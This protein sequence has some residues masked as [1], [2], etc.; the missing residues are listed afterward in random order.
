MGAG[1]ATDGFGPAL[2]PCLKQDAVLVAGAIEAAVFAEMHPHIALRQGQQP[3]DGFDGDVT[4]GGS[5][6][7]Q[8]EFAVAP[9]D[10]G[11]PVPQGGVERSEGGAGGVLRGLIRPDSTE[12]AGV[13]LDAQPQ[14][15]DV[16]RVGARQRPDDIAAIGM[17]DDQPLA[18][19][20]RQ[21]LA[22]R[23]LADPQFQRQ[24]VLT[25]R[26]IG[27]QATGQDPLPRL[28][29]DLIRQQTRGPKR[30]PQTTWKPCAKTSSSSIQIS[31]RP[32]AMA[33]PS[34][35]GMIAGRPPTSVSASTRP[36]NRL[37]I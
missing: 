8:M 9:T 28:G 24:G 21:G 23:D 10:I 25:D 6:Q 4:P 32:V 30:H 1:L 14:V 19:Q 27:G 31:F 34:T 11:Q 13:R 12:N 18:L 33:E 2:Q 26:G 36:V 22:Q 3:V 35:E 5:N 37:P 20:P 15:E 7:R 17:G 29:K 16:F